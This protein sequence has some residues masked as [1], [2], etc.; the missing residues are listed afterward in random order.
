MLY[1]KQNEELDQ[2]VHKLSSTL[3][4]MSPEA[5]KELKRVIWRGTENWNELLQQRAEMSG[6]LVLSDF[7]RKAIENFKSKS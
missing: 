4:E 2:Y 5:M 3:K 1:L 6:R 7:T